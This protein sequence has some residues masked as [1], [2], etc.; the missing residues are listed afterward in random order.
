MLSQNTSKKLL[1]VIREFHDAPLLWLVGQL[2]KYVMKPQP[3]FEK[4]LID[5]QKKM[6]IQKPNVG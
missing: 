2:V 3:S 4:E 1:S 6:N 5:N